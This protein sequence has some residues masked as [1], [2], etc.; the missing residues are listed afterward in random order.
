MQYFY[1]YFWMSAVQQTYTQKRA[2]KDP[3][4]NYLRWITDW[5]V[6]HNENI[7]IS[8]INMINSLIK[9]TSFVV[10][11]MDRP[12]ARNVFW[13]SPHISKLNRLWHNSF[14]PFFTYLFIYLWA[15]EIQFIHTI[16]NNKFYNYKKL[17]KMYTSI[18]KKNVYNII[19]YIFTDIVIV[20]RDI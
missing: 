6:N 14:P 7:I 19:F 11:S 16:I 13:S 17:N 15:I 4:N 9:I 1:L 5:R 12:R 20:K 10:C 8:L 3:I 18:Q 2:W